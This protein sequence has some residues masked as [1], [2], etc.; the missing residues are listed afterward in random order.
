MEKLNHIKTIR[1][2]VHEIGFEGHSLHSINDLTDAQLYGLFELGRVLEPWNRSRIE[3]VGGNVMSTLFFQPSTRTRMSFET[4]MHRLGGAVISEANPLVTSSAAKEESLSDMLRVVS[5][6][7]NLI[8]MRHFNAEEARE[9]APYSES[10]VINAGWGHWEHPTQALLDLYTLYRTF[11]KIEGLKIC[12]ASADLIEARTGHSMA[13]G[14]A[15]LGA[16][17][18]LATQKVKRTPDE[19]LQKISTFGNHVTE[20]FDLTQDTFNELIADMDMVYLPGCSAPKGAEAE[21]FKK[22]MD[23]YLV[24]YETLDKVYQDENR[25]IYV[26]HTLP[27]RAGE[28]DLR[29]DTT[30]HQL[31]FEAIAY[32]VSIRMALVASILGV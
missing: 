25:T 24:R 27:R 17:V 19:V 26:T 23:N 7:A 28:M 16:K 32:S 18:T 29:I 14:L 13:Q 22:V 4:A 9:A 3:L 1:S 12:V 31:Y 5:K 20:E 30:R 8:V 11:G 21:A 10:P 2:I 6:Y 15:R